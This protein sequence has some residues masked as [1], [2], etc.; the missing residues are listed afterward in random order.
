VI[1][2]APRRKNIA[3]LHRPRRAIYA[4]VRHRGRQALFLLNRFRK[5]SLRGHGIN[6]AA[7]YPPHLRIP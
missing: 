5:P 1:V 4:R 7:C 2:I 6:R 3:H